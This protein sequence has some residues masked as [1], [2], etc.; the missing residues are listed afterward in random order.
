[1]PVTG[2]TAL[3]PRRGVD[4]QVRDVTQP[5]EHQ[6]TSANVVESDGAGSRAPAAVRAVTTEGALPR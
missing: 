5:A 1:M 2:A 6:R 4:P 3:Q